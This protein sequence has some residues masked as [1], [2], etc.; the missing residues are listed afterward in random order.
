MQRSDQHQVLQER[1]AKPIGGAW[2]AVLLALPLPHDDDA[3]LEATSFVRI[4]HLPP[5]AVLL[6]GDGE[7]GLRRG[8]RGVLRVP[9]IV[10]SDPLDPGY[11][12][13]QLW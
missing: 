8:G 5:A 6:L 11:P 1:G 12:T 7:G 3:A 4:A 13:G 2:C 10:R 9:D